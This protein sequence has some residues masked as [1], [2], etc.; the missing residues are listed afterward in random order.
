MRRK[1]TIQGEAN[2]IT[3]WAFRNGQ[4]KELH[5][6]KYSE[7]LERPELSRIADAEMKKLKIGISS[8]ITEILAMRDTDP[9]KYATHIDFF[10]RFCDKWEK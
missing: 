9:D 5:A 6:G 3:V 2:A 7:L 1:W 8:K 10:L 4:I